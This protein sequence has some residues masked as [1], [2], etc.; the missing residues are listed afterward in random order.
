MSANKKKRK[1]RNPIE[2]QE[3]IKRLL[4]LQAL[5]LGVKADDIAKALNI[6]PSG[7]RK[8]VSL[9]SVRSSSKIK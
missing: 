2:T 6:N 4:I 5:A 3:A 1:P 7:I 9:K 8:I